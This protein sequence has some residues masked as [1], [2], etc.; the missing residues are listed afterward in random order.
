MKIKVS[1]A[2]RWALSV[3]LLFV[4]WHHAHWSV[5]LMLTLLGISDELGSFVMMK[6]IDKLKARL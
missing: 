3:A 5:A 4:V 2:F 6:L 1:T